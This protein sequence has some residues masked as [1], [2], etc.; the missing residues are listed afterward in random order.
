MP[1]LLVGIIN[2]GGLLNFLGL[3]Q[4]MRLHFKC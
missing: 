1:M 2:N 3:L 4:T